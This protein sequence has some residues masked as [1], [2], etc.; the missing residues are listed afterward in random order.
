MNQRQENLLILRFVDLR[1][2]T[3]TK[4][5]SRSVKAFWNLAILLCAGSGTG[6]DI[7]L[8]CT[9][10]WNLCDSSGLWGS[11]FGSISGFWAS[12]I[13]PLPYNFVNAVLNTIVLLVCCCSFLMN[14]LCQSQELPS[15]RNGPKIVADTSYQVQQTLYYAL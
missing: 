14:I 3:L 8:I 7:W 2:L 6:W 5:K 10:L 12:S 9:W 11:V 15:C 1:V 13:C 4:S